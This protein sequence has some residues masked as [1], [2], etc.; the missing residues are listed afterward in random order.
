MSAPPVVLSIHALDPRGEEGIAGDARVLQELGCRAAVVATCAI[1]GPGAVEI[2]PEIVAHALAAAFDG[3]APA[4]GR[5]GRFSD[6]AQIERIARSLRD[7]PLPPLVVAFEPGPGGDSVRSDLARATADA[8]APLARVLLV[9][10]GNLPAWGIGA[11]SDLDEA[12]EAAARLRESGAAA[13]L[14]TGV[15]DRGRVLDLLDDGG[16]GGAFDAPRIAAPRIEGLAGAHAT[17]VAAHLAMG[18]PLATA[19]SAAQR[20]VARRLRRGW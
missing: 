17:A 7:R 9:R 8:L 3:A 15:L 2:A 18:L 4:A 14:V 11:P 12:R 5:T 20:Y 13:A 16:R 10:A 6:P 19:A 1:A